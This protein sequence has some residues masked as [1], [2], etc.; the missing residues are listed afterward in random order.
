M[1]TEHVCEAPQRRIAAI[2]ALTAG[3]GSAAEAGP[4]VST[5][6]AL[7]APTFIWFFAG[8][9]LINAAH[10][11]QQVTLSWLVYDLTSSGALLGTLNLVRSIA[12]VGLAPVAGVIIDRFPRRKLLYATSLWL[13]AICFG[14]GLVLLGNPA[15]V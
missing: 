8:T 3:A 14:F 11:L 1:A 13:A 5:Y 7:R 15:A 6:A 2:G 9:T 10:W 12:T 4:Q